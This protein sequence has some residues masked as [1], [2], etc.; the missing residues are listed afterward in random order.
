MKQQPPEATKARYERLRAK[1]KEEP[2]EPE[3]QLRE[4]LRAKV[5]EEPE[6]QLRETLRAKVKEETEDA[7][8]KERWRAKVRERVL[9]NAANA[10]SKTAPLLPPPQRA[11]PVRTTRAA[12]PAPPGSPN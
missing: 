12:W 7:T 2:L 4:R 6:E 5:N 1:V 10:K 3:E 9:A 11:S 8:L